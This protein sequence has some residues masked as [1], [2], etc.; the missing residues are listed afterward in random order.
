MKLTT[1]QR[2]SQEVDSARQKYPPGDHGMRVSGLIQEF[3]EAMDALGCWLQNPS[4][5]NRQHLELELTQAAGQAVRFLEEH[6]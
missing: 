1:I 6:P 3:G 4:D 5:R 2:I